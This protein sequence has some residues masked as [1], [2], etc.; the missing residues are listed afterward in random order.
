MS[1]YDVGNKI[2]VT[3]TFTDPLNSD[4]AID[5]TTVYCT[6]R[7]PAGVNT[8]YQYGVDSE[9]TKSDTGVYYIDLPLTTT[10]NWSVRWWGKDSNAKDAVSN[11]D[12][13][14]SVGHPVVS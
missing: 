9:I 4:A 1:T 8:T 13:M 7:S 3:G 5:P 11:W 2:R 10:G 6:V 14:K 12:T